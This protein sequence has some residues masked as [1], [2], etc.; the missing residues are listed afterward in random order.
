M[1]VRFCELDKSAHHFPDCQLASNDCFFRLTNSS[2]PK[3]FSFTV[4]NDKEMQQTLVLKK[5]KLANV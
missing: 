2:K 3:D 1:A 5:L 4:I